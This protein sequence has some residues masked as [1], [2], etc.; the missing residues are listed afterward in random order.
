MCPV[1]LL[2]RFPLWIAQLKIFGHFSVMDF[3]D[4]TT[5]LRTAGCNGKLSELLFIQAGP[6]S[7]WI[8]GHFWNL[9]ESSL[10][11][12]L[13]DSCF[14]LPA[15][16]RTNAKG[17]MAAFRPRLIA[18]D[19]LGSIRSPVMEISSITPRSVTVAWDGDIQTIRQEDGNSQLKI[20]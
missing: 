3:K 2:I 10:F 6:S 20:K 8:G 19:T 11:Q 9:Q 18:I 17:S 7:N 12:R 16:F 4:S 1:L 13:E 5:C 15:L 14:Y